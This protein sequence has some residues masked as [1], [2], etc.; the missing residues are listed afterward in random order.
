MN[1]EVNRPAMIGIIVAV[2]ILLGAGGYFM[3]GRQ[4]PAVSAEQQEKYRQLMPKPGQMGGPPM[5]APQMMP[6]G[7]PPTMRPPGAPGGP[8]MMQPPGGAP[9]MQPPAGGAPPMSP[10]R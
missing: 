2:L 4:T 6:T 9:M 5:G 3:F 10:P 7:A 8:P 1:Q